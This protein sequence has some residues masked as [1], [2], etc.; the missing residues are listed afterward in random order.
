MTEPESAPS[1]FAQLLQ[2]GS[3]LNPSF[4][5]IVD[6]SFSLLAVILL[7]LVYVTAGNPHVFAL[8]G[9]EIALWASVKWYGFSITCLGLVH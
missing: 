7:S 5:A 6:A 2:P 3:S 1:I 4:L 9:I 8:L